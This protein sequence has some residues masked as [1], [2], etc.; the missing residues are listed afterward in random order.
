MKDRLEIGR[1]TECMFIFGLEAA[2]AS[3]ANAEASTNNHIPFLSQLAA[4]PKQNS[5]RQ[6]TA[7]TGYKINYLYDSSERSTVIAFYDGEA[8]RLIKL[9]PSGEV[10]SEVSPKGEFSPHAKL[11]F[12]DDGFS[13]WYRTRKLDVQPFS[14]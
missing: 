6:I 4:S 14:N 8:N 9:D 7:K 1:Q 12:Q 5:L 2:Y 10:L 3:V 13:D 11:I